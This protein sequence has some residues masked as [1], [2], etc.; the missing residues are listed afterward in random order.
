[1]T[2]PSEVPVGA[3]SVRALAYIGVAVEDP[4]AWL[5]FGTEV[6]GFMPAREADGGNRL[7]IDHRAWRIAVGQGGANDLDFMGFEVSGDAELDAI[8][9]RLAGLGHAVTADDGELARDRGVS[10]LIHCV[11]PI[12]IRIEVVSGATDRFE[13]PFVSPCGVSGFVTGE[14]GL[15]H[16]VLGSEDIAAMRRFY[17]D[18]LGFR[19]S[20]RIRMPIGGAGQTELEF[21]HC[22]PRHHTLALV[23]V[24]R[25]QRIFHFMVQVAGIDDVGFA[26]DRVRAAGAKVTATLGRHTNDHMVSFY[27]ATPGGI[28]VEY[29]C[30]A[31]TI[32]EA[33]WRVALHHRPSMWGHVRG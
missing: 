32:D 9:C 6:L 15:G 12:G 19:L 14:Q 5:R 11:D 26:L 20:D 2:S 33:V 8:A 27:A 28:E 21:Y 24:R 18:G 1:M 16:V 30:G 22:N 13:H 25:P 10:R 17:V 4:Q 31:R 23:P 3:V 29:G 7:R